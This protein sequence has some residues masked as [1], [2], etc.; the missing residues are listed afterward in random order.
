MA[1]NIGNPIGFKKKQ[2]C[3][4]LGYS[5]HSREWFQAAEKLGPKNDPRSVTLFKRA[6]GG[7]DVNIFKLM[8]P[9]RTAVPMYPLTLNASR[10]RQC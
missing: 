10:Y 2:A 4:G 3:K 1:A 6:I 5:S 8:R 7:T 9:P